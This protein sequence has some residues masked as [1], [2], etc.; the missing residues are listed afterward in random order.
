M[1][2]VIGPTPPGT[3]VIYEAFGSTFTK[4]TSP[5]SVAPF[6]S[7]SFA[8]HSRSSGFALSLVILFIPTSITTAPSFTISSLIRYGT[9]AATTRISASFVCDLRSFVSIWHIVGVAHSFKKRRLIG[10][11]TISLCPTMVTSFPFMGIS[12]LF[13]ISMTPAGVAGTR[14]SCFATRLPIFMG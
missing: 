13:I 14:K 12:Y 1:A 5:I 8:L 3:G 4:S 11:P 6:S 10:F 9:P 7:K 2:I